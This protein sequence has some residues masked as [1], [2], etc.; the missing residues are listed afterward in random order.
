MQCPQ[1]QTRFSDSSAACPSCAARARGH[2]VLD[3]KWILER[4]LGLG[5]MATVYLA[6]DVE[7][8][9][10]VA[11]KMMAMDQVETAELV[12]RFERE[13][14][15]MARLDHPNVVPVYAVGRRGPTPYIVMK[16]LE[17]VSLAEHL[18]ARGRLPLGEV[19]SI[20]EQACEGLRFIHDQGVVHRD[21]KP[22]N[23]FL[24]PNGHVTLLDL[25]VAHDTRQQMTRSGAVVGTPRYMAP[26]Q[27]R[28]DRI[29]FRADLYSLATVIFEM[30]TGVPVFAY[31]SAFATM[32]AHLDE[33]P[34]AP[35]SLADVPPSLSP[36]L[37]CALAK[38]PLERYGSAAE[39]HQALAEAMGPEVKPVRPLPIADAPEWAK[40]PTPPPPPRRPPTPRRPLEPELPRVP[41]PAGF[42]ADTRVA[43]PEAPPVP[44]TT[45]DASI[46]PGSAAAPPR[47]PTKQNVAGS[48][49]A[50]GLW[51]VSL[52][53]AGV[54]V[55]VVGVLV[56]TQP[57]ASEPP[58]EPSPPAAPSPP[59]QALP[60]TP[61]PVPA[62]AEHPYEEPA[63]PPRIAEAPPRP[64]PARAPEG[65]LRLVA[66][67]S[68]V[69]SW[70]YVDIDGLP[71]G[72]TPLTLHLASGTH[73]LVFRREG[74]ESATRRVTLGRGAK[75]TQ[76]VNLNAVPPDP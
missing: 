34:R 49:S 41:T 27:V 4:Q 76:T 36:V 40:G 31:D 45:P 68:G 30:L 72:T 56:L 28:G 9:R 58:V 57:S 54:V 74:Y 62:P 46:E 60:S 8:E 3:G 15:M 14:K 47:G 23:I 53:V 65:E 37:S 73:T 43:T 10:R 13:A 2:E 32:R 75:K 52:W 38:E 66:K 17:G 71:R 67:T 44:A 51:P 35:S 5:G 39:L 21:L 18:K 12:A 19:L 1:C 48:R 7:L 33:P 24:A 20:S 70:A 42:P 69:L 26:E 59:P 55:V 64:A 6:H 11:V 61:P 22:A 16:Y 25:G 50:R 63:P 29:D